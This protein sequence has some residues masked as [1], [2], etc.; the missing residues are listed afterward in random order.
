MEH[1]KDFE[2]RS[3]LHKKIL[4]RNH[5]CSSTFVIDEL[6]LAHGKKRIDV[7]VLN[8]C[9]HGYEIKSS[10]DNLT[11]LPEQLKEYQ[12][13]LQK[14]TLVVAE[15]HLEEVMT[16]APK[17]CGIFLV[18]KGSRGG[19]SFS[20]IQR[21]TVNPNIDT[22]A[23]AHLLWRKEAIELL[24]R[25]GVDDKEIKGSK[26]K[27]YENISTLISVKEL[28]IWIKEQFSKREN[29]RLVLQS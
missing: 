20:K 9:L 16:L 24:V 10:K 2:I 3:A 19:I 1:T 15:N 12:R 26:L 25:L 28:V 14:L 11:R 8:G 4:Q 27:L 18:T 17:W 23:L 7:A 29:W 5:E 22:I 21:A 13:S 6:G